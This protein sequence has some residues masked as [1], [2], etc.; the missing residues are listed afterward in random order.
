ME[1]LYGP[2]PTLL[3]AATSIMY[4]VDGV[5]SAIVV[6]LVLPPETSLVSAPSPVYLTKYPVIS[7]LRWIHGTIPHWTVMLDDVL[8]APTSEG[9]ADGA[10]CVRGS[11]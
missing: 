8:V 7:P 2:L 4:S 5:S 10:V 1:S 11:E 3:T 9:G 6:C